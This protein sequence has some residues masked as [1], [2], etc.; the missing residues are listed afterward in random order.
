[1]VKSLI[2]V[3]PHILVR[4]EPAVTFIPSS[5]LRVSIINRCGK[6]VQRITWIATAA[7]IR[8]PNKVNKIRNIR[9][10]IK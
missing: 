10:R 8:S 6:S 1:M 4:S 7:T 9:R 2:V 3:F 5:L